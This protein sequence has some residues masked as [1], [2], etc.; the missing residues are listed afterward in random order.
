MKVLF[1]V[2]N[3]KVAESI[4]RKYQ[5]EYKEIITSKTVYYYNAIIKELQKDKTYDRIIIGEDLE[6]FASDNY[7]AIDKYI[8]E[9]MDIISDEATNV[10]GDDIPIIL[11][12][13]DR[14]TKNDP[15]L[16]KLFGLGIYNVLI[17]Q[18]RS[19]QKVC[20]LMYKPRSKKEAK[21]YYKVETENIGYETEKSNGVNETEIQ[22]IL[23]HYK[24]I[25]NN[26][27]KC[28]QSFE[29]INSQYSKEQ[30]KLIIEVLPVNV[31]VILEE[32]SD[33]YR[34]I[35]GIKGKKV[36]G[37]SK[38][39]EQDYVEKEINTG[40]KLTKPV[41]IPTTV[42]TKKVMKI[43]NNKNDD[44]KISKQ[45]EIAETKKKAEEERI[46]KQQALAEAK[47][48]EEER[49]AKEK[50]ELEAKKK[51]EEKL[52]RQ[53]AIEEAKKKAQESI[54][55]QKALAEARKKEKERLA[56]EKAELEAKKKEEERLAKEKAEAEAKKKEEER[57][58]KEKAELEAK[59]KEEERLAKEKAE[60]EAKKK[61]EER[62]AKEKAELEAK[63]KEE[64][65]LAKEKAKAE[66]KKKEEQKIAKEKEEII[67]ESAKR[68]RGRPR[69]TPI[70]VEEEVVPIKRKRG[71][72]RK[73]E[74]EE[75]TQINNDDIVVNNVKNK[76]NDINDDYEISN[77]K[78]AKKEENV[79]E[80][81]EF[82]DGLLL[83]LEDDIVDEFE[84]FENFEEEDLEE[85]F[86]NFED[87]EDLD[88]EFESFE[89]EDLDDEFESFEDEEDLEDE[90][91][92]FEDEED[93]D[94]EFESFEDEEDL[95]D[96]FERFEDEED[97]DDEFERFEDEEDLDDEFESF[98]DEED[99]DEFE[100]FEDEE[101]LDDEFENFEGEDELEDEFENIENE[102]DLDDEFESFEDEEDEEDLEDE[103]ENFE[104]EEDLEEESES[105]EEDDNN[106][107]LI[108]DDEFDFVDDYEE[109]D[110]DFIDE[111]E[112][113]DELPGFEEEEI[114]ELPGFEDEEEEIDELP[115]FEDE[116]EEIDELSGFEDEEEFDE[117]PG[118]ED[119]EDK[120]DELPGFEDEEDEIDELPGF[121]DE[122]DEINE[123]PGFED[124]EDDVSDLLDFDDEEEHNEEPQEE[125]PV[126]QHN[127]AFGGINNRNYKYDNNL[128][129]SI[130]DLK[131]TES[132]ETTYNIDTDNLITGN[133]KIVSFVGTTKNGTSFVVN[134]LAEV[135]SNKGIKTAIL[136][137]TKNKNSYYIYTNNEEQ[138]RQRAH[139]S[140]EKLTKGIAEG[141][142]V[143][144]NLSVYTSLPGNDES[145]DDVTNIIQT[146][147]DNYTVVLMDCDF[148]TDPRYFKAAQE[149]YLVQ[150]LDVL[151]IQPLTA[152]LRDL[153]V[154]G[155]LES[156]KLRIVINKNIK[157]NS[158]NDRILI[159]GMSVYN[160]PAMTYM[161]ELFDKETI[162]YV[163]I[164]F[165]NQAYVKY[166]EAM[167][168]CKISTKGYSKNMLTSLN[169]LSDMVYPTLNGKKQKKFNDY[170]KNNKKYED[171]FSKNTSSTLIKMKKK[172]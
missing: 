105:F 34:K 56:K 45:K 78:K 144:K 131:E 170:S 125:L 147:L 151:T 142:E 80:F 122:E 139:D 90:F 15:L 21:A 17:G 27:P 25:G 18:D 113:I 98:E 67:V 50:A 136:D 70:I 115:E 28:V 97:L 89:E 47:K 29:S 126:K 156:Y 112:E 152:F 162:K 54:A 57:L 53:K 43:K 33:T 101:D 23:N 7:Q 36:E 165:D 94:D 137:L 62:L 4:T 59:K 39:R 143:N 88:D 26:I 31:K 160:D 140:F 66:A 155:I 79:S 10:E 68:G 161:T 159:G 19:I 63:K 133:Q 12:G 16:L 55:K 172:I 124:E 32:N 149:I 148:S 3:E 93:L 171:T 127:G 154:K 96:E 104:D 117:L 81:D 121:E 58:A 100:S 38:L 14:R 60:A 169:N 52:A 42:N 22:N 6:P 167:V 95:D 129:N 40:S 103:F 51:E 166:L 82:D 132:S 35:M 111:E 102:E 76:S 128:A 61:E 1:A 49:K 150:S 157:V 120:I 83:N 77:K 118:F 135:F 108:E 20:G 119:E 69:K 8:F 65:R 5:E 163:T 164:P 13:L 92:S 107:E 64:Q 72:P 168:N 24:K 87:G 73:N 153:K 145:L 30:I 48:K 11:I 130:K 146:L 158:L 71:R 2:N 138:L 106:E 75:E 74:V 134:N 84:E 99:L 44:E 91:E 37:T 114:D 46:A 141:V 86:E 85:E 109:E 41:I 110:F 9:K 123:L 116:E